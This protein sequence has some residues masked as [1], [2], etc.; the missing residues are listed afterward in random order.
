MWTFLNPGR[1]RHLISLRRT[2]S[3]PDLPGK[4]LKLA[5]GVKISSSLR[6]ISHFTADFG[7]RFSS[8]VVPKLAVNPEI[9]HIET[10][11]QSAVYRAEDPELVK[12]FTAV[13]RDEYIPKEGETIIV[14]AAL[15]E[16]GHCNVP[17]DVPAVEHLFKLD[18]QEKRVAFLDQY[19]GF[20]Y[21]LRKSADGVFFQRYIE[22]ACRALLPSLIWNGVAFEAHA[23]NVVARFET[24]T[25]KVLG[26]IYRDLGGLRIDPRIL[27]E[28]TGVDFQFLPGHC[29]VTQ[30]LEEASPKFYHTFVH[31]HIQ[32]LIRLLRLHTN[33]IGWELLRKHMTSVIP[34]DHKLWDLWMDSERRRVDSK[35]LMRMRMKDSYRDVGQ[36]I[37]ARSASNLKFYR[38]FIAH[39]SI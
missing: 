21:Y 24:A 19:G 18:T 30:S 10:E 27:K 6:T 13:V 1:P 25:G 5:I 17:A 9:L 34:R 33:G 20:P 26:F 12:H 38:W 16:T 11:R 29:V 39:T 2:V 28:S 7:P 22:I 3:L 15:L 31:N 23:Q 8:Q 37:A 35:C 14:V 4:P 32:R 36:V